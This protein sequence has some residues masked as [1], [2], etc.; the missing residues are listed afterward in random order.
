MPNE[1]PETARILCQAGT[2]LK[3]T[4][5]KAADRFYKALVSRCGK[6]LLGQ[7]ATEL[8]WFPEISKNGEMTPSK[9]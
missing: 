5:P 2:W 8:R 3:I 6:T 4:N 7:R 1:T 9:G